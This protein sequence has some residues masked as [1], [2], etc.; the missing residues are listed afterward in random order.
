MIKAAFFPEVNCFEGT[1]VATLE[2]IKQQLPMVT[3]L[4]ELLNELGQIFTWMF[5]R[6]S[7]N[8]ILNIHLDVYLDPIH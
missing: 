7:L 8:F 4:S 6:G 3:H 2:P 5:M 1:I